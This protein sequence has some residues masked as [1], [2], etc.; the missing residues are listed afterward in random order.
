MSTNQSPLTH[1]A[2]ILD[3]NRRFAQKHKKPII[4][5]HEQGAE[6]LF[7]V[8]KFIDENYPS[9]LEISVYVLS[10]DNLT[11]DSEQ[12]AGLLSLFE[13]YFTKFVSQ[14]EKNK[15]RLHFAGN[16]SVF[17]DSIQEKIVKLEEK[18]SH[19]SKVLHICFGYS[20]QDELIRAITKLQN[21]HVQITH[22]T[23]SHALDIP[24]S[25]QLVIRTG[26]RQR[27]SNFLT[28][29]AVYAEWFYL[30][31]LWPEFTQVELETIFRSYGE[32]VRNFGK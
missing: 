7:E 21:Q 9:I 29:Q 4:W 3:G 20:G 15:C 2:F 6:K 22:K 28:W 17:S 32:I 5:G 18:T 8:I 24:S 12:I 25:P 27:Q 11:R 19:Y 30:D 13:S 14:S 31:T 16:L 26:G 1:V 23:L 10:L